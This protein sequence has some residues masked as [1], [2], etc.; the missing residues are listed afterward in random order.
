MRAVKVSAA[1]FLVAA[2][3]FWV[4]M[5]TAPP[6]TVA[7]ETRSVGLS[8]GEMLIP[9]DLSTSSGADPY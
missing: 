7:S 1:A 3:A 5:A 9:A 4:T 8:P 6:K 2:G